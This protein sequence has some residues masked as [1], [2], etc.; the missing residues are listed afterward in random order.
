MPC[1]IAGIA[2]ARKGARWDAFSHDAD[3]SIPQQVRLEVNL[4]GNWDT[5]LQHLVD[6]TLSL[7]GCKQIIVGH[8]I[9]TDI[10]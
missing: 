1:A 5:R 7:F 6:S 2:T 4:P 9:L 8:T 3:Q 10:T